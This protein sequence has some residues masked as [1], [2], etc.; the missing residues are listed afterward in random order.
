MESDLC[1]VRRVPIVFL[2]ARFFL[3]TRVPEQFHKSKIIRSREHFHVGVP[4]SSINVG[5]VSAGRPDTL[6]VPAELGRV[7]EPDLRLVVGSARADVA[8]AVDAEEEDLVG[9]AG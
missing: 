8:G 2:K 3:R 7:G 1:H 9:L 5:P 4:V 6:L